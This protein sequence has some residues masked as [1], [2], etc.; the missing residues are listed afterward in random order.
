MKGSKSQ[1][2][3]GKYRYVFYFDQTYCIF[4]WF[5]ERVSNSVSVLFLLLFIDKIE[6]DSPSHYS[7]CSWKIRTRLTYF[8]CKSFF[9]L[10]ALGDRKSFF[11]WTCENC[12]ATF[13]VNSGCILCTCVVFSHICNI[14]AYLSPRVRIIQIDLDS[15]FVSSFVTI[16]YQFILYYNCY[17]LFFT[18]FTYIVMYDKNKHVYYGYILYIFIYIGHILLT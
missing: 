18:I 15:F 16:F 6:F 3:V 13:N 7:L 9:F 5:N 12:I 2:K 4:W 17:D 11:Y 14:R 8:L 10:H 1:K